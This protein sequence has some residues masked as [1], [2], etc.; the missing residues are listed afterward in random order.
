[1]SSHFR[2]VAI[3]G[4]GNLGM[5]LLRGV[6]RS[7]AETVSEVVIFD[8][9]P[10][11]VVDFNDP[12]L[13]VAA[14]L[15]EVVSEQTL[16]LL[17]VKPKDVASVASVLKPVIS[18]RKDLLLVSVV[19]GVRITQLRELFGAQ[20]PVV[21]VMPNTPALIGKGMSAIY[22]EEPRLATMVAGLFGDLGRSAVVE[23]EAYIDVATAVCGSG[24]GFVFLIIEA[25]A[26]AA[27]KLGLPRGLALEMAAQTVYGTG[28]MV[29]EGNAHPAALRD[30]VA[31]PGGS[32]IYGIHEL[33]K[34]GVRGALMS[35]IETAATRAAGLGSKQ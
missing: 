1:M 30:M 19:A 11:S 32:T 15:E 26:D 3:V 18:K 13:Q 34:A 12:R 4:I 2:R 21:R 9:N 8:T 6:L 29:L 5:A 22:A 16:L 7:P 31:S 10:V 14:S 33:E 20:L 24:P 35:A 17:A 23:D 27:V 25:I 28:A